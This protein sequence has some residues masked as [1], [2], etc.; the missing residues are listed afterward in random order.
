[1]SELLLNLLIGIASLGIGYLVSRYQ[2]KELIKAAIQIL[3][4]FEAISLR[5]EFHMTH[6]LALRIQSKSFFP[7][8]I[9]AITPGGTMIGEWLSRRFL[10]KDGKPIPMC[11]LWMQVER[12]S[13]GR[14]LSSPKS[15]AFLSPSFS[16]IKKVLIVNDI[17]RSGRT[18]EEA[19]K[20]ARKAYQHAMVRT[21]VIFLSQDAGP[22]YPDF[23]VDRPSRRVV[24]E[25]KVERS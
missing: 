25:W 3:R 17:S 18:L 15:C 9:V 10:R 13:E 22:P 21:A 6:I 8:L 1:M 16:K 4:P 12:D 7:D 14:H 2:S 11:S 24:F 5:D 19:V 23:W 20:F